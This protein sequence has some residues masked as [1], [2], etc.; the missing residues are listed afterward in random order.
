MSYRPQPIAIPRARSVSIAP[1]GAAR[2]AR[3]KGLGQ[4]KWVPGQIS[5]LTLPEGQTSLPS[6]QPLIEA[7]LPI[8]PYVEH[9]SYET[10]M[11]AIMRYGRDP[12]RGIMGL[13]GCPQGGLGCFLANLFGGGSSAP[14]AVETTPTTGF[15]AAVDRARAAGGGSASAS[16]V[17]RGTVESGGANVYTGDAL[18][19]MTYGISYARQHHQ[20]TIIRLTGTPRGDVTQYVSAEGRPSS[21]P[22][23]GTSGLGDILTDYACSESA[24]NTSW[25]ARV[26]AANT[27]GLQAAVVGGIVAGVIGGSTKSAMAGAI[28]G[29]AI[30]LLVNR[31]W[32]SAHDV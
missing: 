23:T 20:P 5:F 30:G 26:R 14:A 27:A 21:R 16:I 18:T 9:G 8:A 17:G 13:G 31:M 11:P 29:G 7:G 32:A 12:Y 15:V 1:R 4:A 3:G 19:A 22:P 2:R 25:I 10:G 6:L 28:G 24:L